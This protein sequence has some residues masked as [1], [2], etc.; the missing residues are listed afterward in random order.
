L[1]EEIDNIPIVFVKKKYSHCFGNLKYDFERYLERG[2]ELTQY[3]HDILAADLEHWKM[4]G[5]ARG[6]LS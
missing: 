1:I 3:E 2:I 5:F 4:Y 6:F